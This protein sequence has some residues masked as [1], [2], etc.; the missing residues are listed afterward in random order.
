MLWFLIGNRNAIMSSNIPAPRCYQFELGVDTLLERQ[1]AIF[2]A[3]AKAL[4]SLGTEIYR[5]YD[6]LLIDQRADSTLDGWMRLSGS[7]KQESCVFFELVIT[8]V[9]RWFRLRS[10]SIVLN[11][12]LPAHGVDPLIA[13]ITKGIGL[14]EW[15]KQADVLRDVFPMAIVA[16]EVGQPVTGNPPGTRVAIR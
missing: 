1:D 15:S 7:M 13:L 16:A 4:G 2:L 12:V 3:A 8:R 9:F 6:L 14:E 10:F 5:P 11:T